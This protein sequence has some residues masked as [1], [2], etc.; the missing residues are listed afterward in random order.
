MVVIGGAAWARL[1]KRAAERHADDL[2]LHGSNAVPGIRPRLVSAALRLSAVEE[3]LT[4][5]D[6]HLVNQDNKLDHIAG[7]LRTSNGH[8]IA[9]AVEN[10]ERR[11]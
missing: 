6:S 10:I 1:G 11:Q 8:T 9:E 5:I 3:K 2:F 7:Q 4:K